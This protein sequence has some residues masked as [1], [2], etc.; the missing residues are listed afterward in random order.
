MAKEK[1]KPHLLIAG[2][3]KV[4]RFTS[5]SSGGGSESRIPARNRV[6]HGRAL[7]QQ[8]RAISDKATDLIGEQRAAGVDVG[9]GVT[10]EFESEPGFELPTERLGFAP[11]KIELLSVREVGKKTFAT[12]FVPE[13]KLVRFE[14]LIESYIKKNTPKGEPKNQRVV[15]NIADIRLA[16]L[17]ALWTDDPKVFPAA[18]AV[19][20]WEVWLRTEGEREAHIRLFREHGQKIGLEISTREIRFM[21][22]TVVAAK[23]TS[24][25]L[26]KSVRLLNSVAEVRLLKETADFFSTLTAAEQKQWAKELLSRTK[27]ASTD[28]PAVCILDTGVNHAHPLIAPALDPNDVQTNNPAWSAADENGHGTELAGLALLGDLTDCLQSSEAIHVAHRLESVKVLRRDGDNKGELYG[29]ITREAIARAETQAPK[30]QRVVCMAVSAK[31]SRDRG[32]PSAWSAT[33]DAL[34]SGADDDTRRLLIVSAGN[35]PRDNWEHYPNSNF[36]DGIHDPGQSWNALTIG[37]YTDKDS[38]D[39]KQYPGFKVVAKKGD[40]GPASCTAETWPKNKWPLKPDVV[41]EGGN[42]AHDPQGG[43]DTLPSLDLLTAHHQPTNRLF[44]L[45]GD[46]SAATA[47]AARMGAAIQAAYPQLWPE[48]VRG[49]IVHSAEWTPT[50]LAQHLG[51]PIKNASKGDIAKLIRRCGFGVP[52]VDRALWSVSN[53][54]TLIAQDE[55]QPF[56]EVKDKDGNRSIKSRDMSLHAIPWPVEVLESLGETDVEMQVTLSYYVE[57]NPAARGWTRR[58]R[59]QSHGLRFD[60]RRPEETLAEFRRRVNQQARDEEDALPASGDDPGWVVGKTNRHVGSIHSDR[61]TGT[62]VALS[63]RGHIAVYPALGWWRERRQLERWGK[64][65][66]YALLVSIRAPA[67]EADIYAAVAA[68]IKTAVAIKVPT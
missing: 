54:L 40:L 65:A 9:V 43:V 17:K 61:W 36:T 39:Q 23:G 35:V 24:A 11:S 20:W 44:T 60:V 27:W 49:L 19:V 14:N 42:G 3:A 1:Q 46:T 64:K 66:R 18:D 4:E 53:S 41:L 51:G 47:L 33:L 6:Q 31:D 2:T 37:A 56:D 38:I 21:E 62:A 12:V 15:A 32:K 58:Y 57:P 7:L 50:M 30:R 8:M 52:S 5:P 63:Q 28:A 48:T 68:E 59:Y 13:G 45:T 10:L 55:V 29:D 16:A 22:R 34:S 26:S 67:V 25:Q